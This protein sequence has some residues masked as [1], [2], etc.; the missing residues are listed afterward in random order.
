MSDFLWE[1]FKNAFL[2]ACENFVV[3]SKNELRPLI[4]HYHQGN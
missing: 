1:S 2:G 4:P 3:F